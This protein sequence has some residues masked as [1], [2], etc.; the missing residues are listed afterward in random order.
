MRASRETELTLLREPN[1][2]GIS[3]IDVSETA[4]RKGWFVITANSAGITVKVQSIALCAGAGQAVAATT[5]SHGAAFHRFNQR[6][7]SLNAE[8]A[9]SGK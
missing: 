8:L 6:L 5:P 1:V 3:G 4:A 2:R 9:A 7:A